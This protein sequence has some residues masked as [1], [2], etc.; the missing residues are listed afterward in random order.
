MSDCV[1][2]AHTGNLHFSPS[3]RTNFFDLASPPLDK[4]LRHDDLG[5]GFRWD[6]SLT[7]RLES[8]EQ[9]DQ[10][11]TI[12]HHA[13][14][15]NKTFRA[16]AELRTKA[17]SYQRQSPCQHSRSCQ[18]DW[19]EHTKCYGAVMVPA[20]MFREKPHSQKA[21]TSSTKQDIKPSC[22][23]NAGSISCEATSVMTRI[24]PN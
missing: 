23:V 1:R 16:R 4:V 18:G 22:M 8:D 14:P 20:R 10:A 11:G 12:F 6:L 19:T 3:S 2:K 17:E 24:N 9:V 21:A 5:G 7:P 15:N 13:Q